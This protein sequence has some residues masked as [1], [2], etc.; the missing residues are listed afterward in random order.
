L[1]RDYEC[2]ERINQAPKVCNDKIKTE[3][4]GDGCH[5]GLPQI[6]E[7]GDRDGTQL[8]PGRDGFSLENG[9]LQERR[10]ELAHAPLSIESPQHYQRSDAVKKHGRKIPACAGYDYQCRRAVLQSVEKIVSAFVL[11]ERLG[12]LAPRSDVPI[13]L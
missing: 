6:P 7:I 2:K 11:D 5:Q 12:R 13:A 10:N 4:T 3:E 8:I 9:F 1:S